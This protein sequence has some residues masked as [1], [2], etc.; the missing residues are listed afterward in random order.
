LDDAVALSSFQQRMAATLLAIFAAVALVL[1]AVGVY[2]V[3]SY[4][5]SA[6][7]QEIGVRL[8]IGAQR[9]DVTWLVV[10]QVAVLIGMGLAIGVAVLVLAGRGI[11]G[12]LFGVQP[13]DPITIAAVAIALA[14]V[15]VMAAW[16]PAAR[17]SRVDPIE[18]LRYE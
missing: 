15:G 4:S 13:V 9:R 7:T 17:A 10:R 11:S 1:A 8:A 18:A 3:L 16:A 2:G 6:R 5:V 14:A 12:L